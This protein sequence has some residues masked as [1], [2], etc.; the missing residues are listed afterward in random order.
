[1]QIL[2]YLNSL[3]HKYNYPYKIGTYN[4]H[5]QQNIQ[6]SINMRITD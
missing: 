2:K 1:M 3:F 5:K 6:R 4:L